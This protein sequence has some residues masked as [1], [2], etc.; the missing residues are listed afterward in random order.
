MSSLE[1][2]LYE[3]R[4]TG[5]TDSLLNMATIL[6][7]SQRNNARDGFTGALAAHDGRYVQVLEGSRQGLDSLMQRLAGDARH[8]DIRVLDRR[9]IENRSFGEWTMASTRITPD[10][11]PLLD[12]VNAGG[13]ADTVIAALR[14]AA[15]AA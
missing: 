14:E 4:A 11:V 2:I 8:S 1:Q 6:A 7:E 3:S 10:L 9:P 15:G 12:Q 13:H 5:S